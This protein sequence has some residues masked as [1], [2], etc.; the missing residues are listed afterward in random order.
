MGVVVAAR[1]LPARPLADRLW[2]P[3]GGCSFLSACAHSTIDGTLSAAG[4]AGLRSSHLQRQQ[5]NE[6]WMPP[7]SVTHCLQPPHMTLPVRPN[8]L[9]GSGG[10]ASN[11]IE[12][13]LTLVSQLRCRAAPPSPAPAPA[14]CARHTPLHCTALHGARSCRDASW[15]PHSRHSP[16]PLGTAAPAPRCAPT[17]PPG[18]GGVRTG[19][20][21]RRERRANSLG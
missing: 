20:G 7:Q 19:R 21:G 14:S 15:G 11:G 8:I 1:R 9:G 6:G 17:P 10:P 5:K 13:S 18:P 4:F 16:S 12:S 3:A 2:G